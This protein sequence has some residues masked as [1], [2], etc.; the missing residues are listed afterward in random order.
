MNLE[1][2]RGGLIV[3]CQAKPDNPLYRTAALPL[4]AKAAE[5]G[6]AVA[7]RADGAEEIGAIARLVKIPI[8]GIRKT[9]PSPDRVY[10]TP[11]FVHAREIAEAGCTMIA[12]DGTSR[13]R[14]DGGSLKDLT[15]RIQEELGLPV[16]ADISVFEE[17]VAAA[18]AGCDVVATTLAGYTSYSVR[19][20]GPDFELLGKLAA[21][22]DVPIIAEG[23]FWT[24]E[25]VVRAFELGAFAVVI[26]KAVTNPMVITQRFVSRLPASQPARKET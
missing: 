21:A 14:P 24:P 18:K 12:L 22:L 15:A 4:M 11:T 23:R 3:S 13:P 7:I 20:E 10:I 6:G 16:M 19:T 9:E 26:G 17:G 8:I 1:L 5:A 2:L 25:E